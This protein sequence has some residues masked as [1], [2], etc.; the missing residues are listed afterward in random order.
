MAT[1]AA[2]PRVVA[3]R[4]RDLLADQGKPIRGARVLL[5][6][7]SYKPGVQDTRESSAIQLARDLLALGAEVT[8]WDPIARRLDLEDGRVLDQH[9]RPRRRS[10]STPSSCTPCTPDL[11]HSWLERRTGRARRELPPRRGA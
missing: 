7:A 3:Q 10:T 4:L 8:L 2:R 5:V 1:I 9:R 11:D 6:G